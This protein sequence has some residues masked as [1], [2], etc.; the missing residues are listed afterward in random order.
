MRAH[1]LY[2]VDSVQEIKVWFYLYQIISYDVKINK[3]FYTSHKCFGI[4]NILY[5]S[6]IIDNLKFMGK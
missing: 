2:L 5:A 3:L 1:P 4:Q 6:N